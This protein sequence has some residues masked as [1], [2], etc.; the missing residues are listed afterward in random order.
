M[1]LGAQGLLLSQDN[2]D[3]VTSMLREAQKQYQ[4]GHSVVVNILIGKTDFREG[5]LAV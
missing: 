3:Q 5:A 1:G 4:D 2:E